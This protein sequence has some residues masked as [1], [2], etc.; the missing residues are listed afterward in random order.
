MIPRIQRRNQRTPMGR[1]SYTG[2]TPQQHIQR[3]G[4]GGGGGPSIIQKETGEQEKDQGLLGAALGAKNTYDGVKAAY[5]GGSNINNYFTKPGGLL[6]QGQD[7]ATG[8]GNFFGNSYQPTN[9]AISEATSRIMPGS[10][11]AGMGGAYQMP[12]GSVNAL[13]Q[14]MQELVTPG[15]Q[16]SIEGL[17]QGAS[18]PRFDDNLVGTGGGGA[19]QGL[20]PVNYDAIPNS[21]PV[22]ANLGSTGFTNPS[23][24]QF[25]ASPANNPLAL[26]TA[27]GIGPESFASL[28]GR[29]SNAWSRVTGLGTQEALAGTFGHTGG[30]QLGAGVG[31]AAAQTGGAAAAQAGGQAAAK[32]GGDAAAKA[33]SGG[34]KAVGVAGG[35]LGAGLSVND[36]VENGASVANVAGLTSGLAFAAAPFLAAAGPV[37]WLALGIGAVASMFDWDDD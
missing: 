20:A 16:Q 15:M 37:G 14:G 18:T 35:L 11:G 10:S 28:G 7:V 27:S 5:K 23:E 2:L 8:V 36:I 32:A 3:Q 9:A 4:G 24:V 25:G 13:P 21:Q 6:E 30:A 33:A 17:W 31:E 22:N 1:I 26:S 34:S 12:G 19:R 29:V